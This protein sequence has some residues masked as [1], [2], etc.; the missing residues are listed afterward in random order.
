VASV[1]VGIVLR[2]ASS[3]LRGKGGGKPLLPLDHRDDEDK[4]VCAVFTCLCRI[5]LPLTLM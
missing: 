3:M 4:V 5:S 2:S 1:A